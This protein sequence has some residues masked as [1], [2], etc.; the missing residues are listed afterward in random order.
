MFSALQAANF[1]A[2][3]TKV[4]LGLQELSFLGFLLQEGHI[5]PDHEKVAAIHRL[6]PPHT[7]SELRAFL[8]L[9]GYYREFVERYSHL[10]K[11]LTQLL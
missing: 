6:Q 1:K 9:T 10:A 3:A 8:G 4:F 7:R 5:K 11:P 2:G